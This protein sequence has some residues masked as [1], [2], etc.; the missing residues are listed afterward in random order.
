MSSK[1]LD[2]ENGKKVELFAE[3]ENT[4]KGARPGL[5]ILAHLGTTL[6]GHSSSRAPA[7]SATTVLELA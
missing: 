2:C 7:G 6:A 4:G 1:F 5:V 3:K